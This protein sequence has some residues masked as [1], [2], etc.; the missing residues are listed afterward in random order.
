[1]ATPTMAIPLPGEAPEHLAALP[2]SGSGS[3]GSALLPRVS[4]QRAAVDVQG[5][6]PALEEAA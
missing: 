1:M 6:A 4:V 3:D 2:F 5:L